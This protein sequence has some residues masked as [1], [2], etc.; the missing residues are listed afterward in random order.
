MLLEPEDYK[1]IEPLLVGTDEDK[2]TMASAQSI[3]RAPCV[4]ELLEFFFDC[5]QLMQLLIDVMAKKPVS[6]RTIID[7]FNFC[8]LLMHLEC[9]QENLFFLNEGLRGVLSILVES[10]HGSSERSALEALLLYIGKGYESH[11][12]AE[13]P[14]ICETQGR[15]HSIEKD[16]SV[17]VVAKLIEEIASERE[18]ARI[19]INELEAALEQEQ[20]ARR[21]A[22][23]AA[24]SRVPK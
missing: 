18:V 22:E 9:R 24:G 3:M 12:G 13:D 19:R 20:R 23:A 15:M 21:S 14:A 7:C 6:R 17:F 2:L 11:G 8:P 4:Q 16:E 1:R 5:D 10:M